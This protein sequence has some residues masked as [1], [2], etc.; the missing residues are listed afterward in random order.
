MFY[1]SYKITLRAKMFHFSWN[2]ILD[3]QLD[4]HGIPFLIIIWNLYTNWQLLLSDMYDGKS[5]LC[6][7]EICR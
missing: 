4:P 2:V 7:F 1:N 3:N 6:I 5:E